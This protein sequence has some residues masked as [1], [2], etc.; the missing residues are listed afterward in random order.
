VFDR[1]GTPQAYYFKGNQFI[2]VP[3]PDNAST[4]R[5]EYIYRVPE[6][7]ADADVSEIPTIYHEMLCVFAVI[8][9]FARDGLESALFNEKK[10]QM[11]E[12]LKRDAEQRNVDQPR[13]VVQ[14]I[15][16]EANDDIW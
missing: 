2:L 8:D 3:C 13:T 6:M 10:K 1:S 4:L 7:S 5:M 14:T 15:F 9:G 16:D 11:I 12:D